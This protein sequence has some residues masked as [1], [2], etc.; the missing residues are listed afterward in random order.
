MTEKRESQPTEDPEDAKP[1]IKDSVYYAAKDGLSIALFALLSKVPFDTRND[2]VNEVCIH[3]DWIS[4]NWE[5]IVP[6]IFSIS[7]LMDQN[8]RDRLWSRSTAFQK[9][10]QQ[11]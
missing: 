8:V 11:N 9:W 3:I 7:F 4:S 6:S 1:F 10:I 5:M 2:I